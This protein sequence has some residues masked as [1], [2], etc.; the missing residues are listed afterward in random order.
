MK[1]LFYIFLLVSF[2]I[3][4]NSCNEANKN[5]TTKLEAMAI[6]TSKFDEI[7]SQFE[8]KNTE[9][10]F[11]K[12]A[13]WKTWKKLHKECM[14]SEWLKNPYYFGVSNT[15][16]IGSLVDKNFDLQ[17]TM[18]STSGFTNSELTSLINYGNYTN[19]G[20]SQEMSMSLE[21]FLQSEFY[22]SK[23]EETDIYAE[24]RGSIN[25]SKTTKISV[26]NWRVNNIKE[27]VLMDVL[28]D[29]PPTNKNKKRF[30]TTLNKRKHY[31]LVKVIEI[32]GFTSYIV[33]EENISLDLESK[34]KKGIFATLGS[35]SAEVK[36]SFKNKRTIEVKSNGNFYVF[37]EF[38]KAKKVSN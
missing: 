13:T 26:D 6:E 38:K 19:C 30:L 18:D 27:D 23:T 31:I 8:I 12:G 29:A 34:L 3:T 22:F 36:F 25:K 10:N 37:G 1:K 14:K 24:L 5:E 2:I 33:L 20:Y 28:S 9:L 21:V 16:N 32:K 4:M 11:G 17:R 35:G 7:D 15:V